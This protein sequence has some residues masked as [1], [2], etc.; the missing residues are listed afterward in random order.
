MS[1]TITVDTGGTFSD[2]V[3]A[4]EHEVLGLYKGATTPEDVFEGIQVALELAAE[5]QGQTVAELLGDTRTFVYST[6]HASNAIIVG[7]TA[8]TAFVTTRGHPD[9]LV[10]REGGRDNSLNL[11]MPYP[12]PYVPRSLTFELDERVLH[13][14]TVHIPLDEEACRRVLAR[15]GELEVE[16]VGVCLLWSIVNPSHEVRVGELIDEM[17]PGVEYTLSHELNPL[18][19]EYRRASATVIDASLKPLMRAHLEDID[20]RLRELGFPSDPLMVTHISG[21]VMR[22]DEMTTKPLHSV[23]SGPALA[24]VAGQVYADAGGAS[25]ISR[26]VLVVDAGGTS[27][28]VGPLRDGHIVYT[29]EKWLGEKWYGHMTG[30]PAVDTRSIGAGGG[31]I[32]QVDRG[33]LLTVGPQSAGAH[34]GPACY[35]YGGD[36]PTVTDAAVAVGYIDPAFFL[37]GRMRLDVDLARRA[38]DDHVASRLGMSVE[39]AASAILTVSNENMRSFV[40]ELTVAQG[41]NP[42]DCII[43]AGG[44]SSGLGIVSIARELGVLGVFIPKL[45]AGLSAV[46]GQYS[47]ITSVFSQGVATSSDSFDYDRVN[48]AFATMHKA[49]DEADTRVGGEGKRSRAFTAEARYANQLW[50][51]DVPLGDRRGFDGPDDV[52]DLQARFD[53]IHQA[54]FAVNEPGAPIE[55][56]AWRG[57]TRTASARPKLPTLPTDESLRVEEHRV[58]YFEGRSIETEI[59]RAGGLRDGEI[60]EGPAIIEEETTTIVAPPGST[61]EVTAAAYIATPG[62]E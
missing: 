44:G 34:P 40:T 53:D 5:D 7:T 50:E 43:V 38:I 56:I 26:D 8:R 29:R 58:A 10:Y 17:L 2:L 60:I 62:G 39:E 51:I 27:F 16:A 35:G 45:A 19:R 48:A 6:T 4:D 49:M 14:G 61:I 47:D 22:M 54:V 28:D 52:A 21:G 9:I 37:G 59:F 11:A 24:P 1:Y 33:G 15:L 30:L 32:A 12:E 20:H 42:K 55:V 57:E 41:I 25:E 36:R 23:D 46:G 13:D 18:A 31:S 3:L